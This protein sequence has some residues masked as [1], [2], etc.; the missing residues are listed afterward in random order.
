MSPIKCPF[1][2]CTYEIGGAVDASVMVQLLQMHE[3]ATHA[4]PSVS[5]TAEKVRRPCVSTGGT[6]EDWSY[7]TTRWAEYK[8]AIHLTDRNCVTQLLECCEETLR[9]DLTRS[10][11]GSL[12]NRPE[13]EV[14][15]AIRRLAQAEYHSCGEEKTRVT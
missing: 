1:E 13:D 2:G 3:A 9:R 15:A 4:R 14:L 5:V 8:D 7:F 12:I 6:S 11:G 10:A